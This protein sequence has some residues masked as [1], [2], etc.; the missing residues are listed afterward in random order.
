MVGRQTVIFWNRRFYEKLINNYINMNQYILPYNKEFIQNLDQKFWTPFLIFD[1]KSMRENVKKLYKAFSWLPDFKNYYAVKAHPNPYILEILKDEW[2]GMDCSSLWELILSEAIWNIGE[3]IMFTSNNTPI[4]DFQKAKELWAVMNFDD[5]SHIEFYK[6]NV[7]ELPDLVSC[8]YNPWDSKT[9]W[10]VIIWIPSEAKFGFTKTQIIEWYK[11]LKAWWSKRFWLHTMVMSNDLNK[12]SLIE[13]ATLLIKLSL[14][15]E[16][17]VWIEIEFLNL[18]WWIGIAHTPKDDDVDVTYIANW[19]KKIYNEFIDNNKRK[20]PLNIVMEQ[21]RFITWPYA[22]LVSKVRHMKHIYR[23]Y[24]WLDSSMSDFM[25]P[26]M[27]WVYHHFTVMWKENNLK[28][29]V[30]DVVWSLCENNDKFAIQ[31]ELPEVN[32][33]DYVA[34]HHAWAHGNAMWF[35]YNAKLKCKEL[36]LKENWEIELIKRAEVLEDYFKTTEY[37]WLDKILNKK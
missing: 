18:G 7:W 2:C 5:I 4:E 13:T 27:Y 25:R 33:W 37:K 11:K 10:N 17:E 20:A 21:W 22:Q 9:W 28:D 23:D 16:K 3:D 6:K 34:L 19:I 31:R 24:V 1:E 12:D 14:E 8:R 35:N 29:K 15:I 26:W 30:Y 36:L 32:V